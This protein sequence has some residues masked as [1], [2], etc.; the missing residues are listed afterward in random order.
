MRNI[1]L[2]GWP[3]LEVYC[4]IVKDVVKRGPETNWLL[5]CYWL[6]TGAAFTRSIAVSGD[7]FR[8]GYA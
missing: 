6:P 5:V 3:R 8:L 2:V 7:V 1:A 4:Y